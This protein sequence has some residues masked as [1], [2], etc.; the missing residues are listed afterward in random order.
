MATNRIFGVID[1]EEVRT[2]TLTHDEPGGIEVT[3]TE[4]GATITSVRAPDADGN[5]GEVTLG[6][7]AATPY[8]DG[9]SPYFGCIAGRCANRTA[10]GKFVLDQ[11]SYELAT[12]NGLNH[13]HGGELGF[14]KRVWSLCSRGGKLARFQISSA[15]GDQGYPGT[16]TAT[17]TYSL[18]TPTSLRIEYAAI[19]DAPTICNLTNHAYWNL[20]DGGATPM[21]AHE[22]ELACDFYT[23]VDET[24]IPTGEVRQVSGAMDLRKRTAIGAGI[25]QAD[26]GNGYDHNYC[27]SSPSGADGLRPVARLWDP[28]SG[29]WM[30]VRS[31]QPGVQFYSGNFLDGVSGRAG[32]AYKK[33]HGLCLETQKFPDAANRPHFPDVT[34]RPGDKYRHVTEHAFGASRGPPTGD[35]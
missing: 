31:D 20:A 28:S 12:N 8:R 9:T 34:L 26:N 1:G 27:V 25:G 5:M 11:K 29:R 30:A 19:T 13:L 23:P 15:D 17:V 4:I 18:P 10:K 33:H 3:V 14:D 6:F 35:W 21:L 7:D 24:S 32:V 16:L 22:I 2:Y